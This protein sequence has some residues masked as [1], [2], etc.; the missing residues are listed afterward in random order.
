MLWPGRRAASVRHATGVIVARASAVDL[1]VL[2]EG[3]RYTINFKSI[4]ERFC[5]RFCLRGHEAAQEADQ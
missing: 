2:G 1:K 3:E 4:V 5:L